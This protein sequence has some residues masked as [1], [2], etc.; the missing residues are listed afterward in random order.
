MWGAFKGYFLWLHYLNHGTSDG[1]VVERHV[2]LLFRDEQGREC[3]EEN[4]GG[5]YVVLDFWTT[6]CGICFKKF[7]LLEKTFIEGQKS[8]KV[9][10]YAVNSPL[11][12][13]SANQAINIIKKLNYTFPVLVASHST[14]SK[15]DIRGYPTVFVLNA[16]GNIIYQGNLEGIGS[17]IK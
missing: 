11:E 15:L 3:T 6:S 10:V 13:D 8:G 14:L 4:L 5:P 16:N 1:I 7:P 2:D 17:V 12:R 9:K